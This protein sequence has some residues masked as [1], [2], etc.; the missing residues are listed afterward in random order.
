MM[1][2][3][4]WGKLPVVFSLLLGFSSASLAVPHLFASSNG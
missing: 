3:K 1:D 4:R 2:L